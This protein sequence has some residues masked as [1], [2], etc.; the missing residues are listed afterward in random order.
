[1]RR[2]SR[3]RKVHDPFAGDGIAPKLIYRKVGWP[4]A[5]NVRG[6][7]PVG[8]TLA[9]SGDRTKPAMEG[10]MSPAEQ[11]FVLTGELFVLSF[12]VIA[13]L[14]FADRLR[15]NFTGKP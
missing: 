4:V 10:S 14:W 13:A 3:A 11:A 2:K 12:V 1:M 6:P 9:S 5:G 7:P 15:R 8:R